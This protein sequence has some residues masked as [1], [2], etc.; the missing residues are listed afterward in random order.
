MI[1]RYAA[2]LLSVMVV[3]GV[4]TLGA[5]PPAGAV[6]K[7]PIIIQGGTTPV[8]SGLYQ[9]VIYP[10]FKAQFPQYKLEYVSV[11]TSQAITNAEAGQ[12]DVVLTHSPSVENTFVTQGYSY[13][14]G[15]RLVMA[16]DF[17][18]V[19]PKT[20]PANA[21]ALGYHNAV[22]AFRAI[23]SAGAAGRAEFVSRGDGSGTNK[24]ELS[25]W[26]LT[27]IPLTALGEPADAANPGQDAPWYH[28]S[29]V[30]QGQNLQ[31]TNQCPFSSGECYTL[32]DIGTFNHLSANGSIP[33]LAVLSRYNDG[34]GALGGVSLLLNPYHAYA[35]NPAK[36]TSAHINLTGALAFLNFLTS[37]ATQAAIGKYPSSANPAFIPDARPA[38]AITQNVPASVLASSTV[39]VAGTVKPNYFLD[40]PI[41][42]S[43][44]FL[45][46][47]GAPG[48]IVA[49][50]TV[51]SSGTF[52]IAFA[53]TVTDTYT[54][55]VP[56]FPDGLV[57]PTNTAYRQST[58][59][60]LRKMTV[61]SA[62]TIGTGGKHGLVVGVHGTA[63]PLTNRQAATI[64]IQYESGTT[65]RNLASPIKMKNGV[66]NFSKFVGLPGRGTWNLRARYSDPGV[67]TAANSP[68]APVALH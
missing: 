53:P 58:G 4:A 22:G 8:D 54:I 41:T 5:A 29:G 20:D 9:N 26:K 56:A 16:S 37:P 32:A 15:G 68:V 47:S 31:I 35:V 49:S 34:P 19:G 62:V 18:T 6:T 45:E 38:V 25:I 43:P 64:Q 48:V 10:M 65:W 3:G 33:K 57:L 50:T 61:T 27:G 40:P 55:F 1:R 59:A 24:N 2:L 21:S 30:G 17:V 11:G 13:E 51:T 46:R 67:V 60:G 23:A 12:G 14:A 66:A 39:T 63:A 36:I 42:G 52:S 28:K 44:V 7:T